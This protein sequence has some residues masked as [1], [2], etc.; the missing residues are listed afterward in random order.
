MKRTDRGILRGFTLVE[1]LVVIAIIGVLVA[2]LLPAIQAA[3]EAARRNTCTNHLKQLGLALLNYHNTEEEFP[4]GVAGGVDIN[5]FPGN[6][7][8]GYG[9]GVA[10]L[11]QLEQRALYEQ[12]N[13]DWMPNVFSTARITP[14][15][16]IPGGDVQ[17][18]VFRCPSSG[19]PDVGQSRNP[20]ALWIGYA[21]SDYKASTGTGDHGMFFKRRDGRSAGA[22]GVAKSRG[23][24]RVRIADITDGLSNTIALGESAYFSFAMDDWPIWMGAPGTDESALFK[25]DSNA[26]D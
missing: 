23:Y 22:E 4:L 10:I 1:L 18:E 9:W 16:M 6:D 15:G 14:E 7:D 26:S 2:L 24:V 17:L 25:T 5:Y 13:P 12:I 3:R 20:A 19:L 21:T 11:P 8:D